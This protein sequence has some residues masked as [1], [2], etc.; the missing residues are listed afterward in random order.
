MQADMVLEM[1]LRV[2][3]LDLKAGWSRQRGGGSLPHRAEPEHRG[4]PQ[5]PPHSDTLPSTRLHLLIVSLHMG[6]A[7]K[8]MS[9]LGGG[10]LVKPP[11]I[12]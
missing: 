1:E 9:L 5:S 2:V 11:Q 10:D 8:Q 12:P 4:R 6:Q 3:R 7:F